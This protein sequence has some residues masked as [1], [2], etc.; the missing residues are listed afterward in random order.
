MK[1]LAIE[2]VDIIVPVQGMFKC[3]SLLE[4]L[5]HESHLIGSLLLIVSKSCSGT[6]S[7]TCISEKLLLCLGAKYSLRVRCFF[8]EKP[9]YPGAARNIGLSMVESKY[10]AFLDVNTFPPDHWLQESLHA[11]KQ[12]KLD[13]LLG[14]AQYRP[15]RKSHTY[16]IAATYGFLPLLS[17]PG[18]VMKSSCVQVVGY[19]LPDIRA[20]EDI[21]YLHRIRVLLIDKTS[22]SSNPCVYHLRQGFFAYL[23]KWIRNYSQCNPYPTLYNQS[24]LLNVILSL[25][26]VCVAYNWNAAI[27][28][29][30]ETSYL[31]LENVTKLTVGVVAIVYAV[32][33]VIIPSIS[34]QSFYRGRL[35]YIE[36]PLLFL[37]TLIFDIAKVIG[38]LMRPLKVM[39]AG[40][41]FKQK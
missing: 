20:A 19:F 30:N 15:K 33:R 36:L 6:D 31:Y 12:D 28:N 35:L 25:L 32:F 10:V 39:F 38:F 4:A 21:D 17:L 40:L 24:F 3:E 13:L 22:V 34:K 16:I 5:S 1:P 26:L 41:P 9:L 29:W 37:A 11:L 7:D 14:T 18:T 2:K 8:S 23:R 27:A